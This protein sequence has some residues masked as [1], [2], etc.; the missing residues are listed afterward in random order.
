MFEKEV[1]KRESLS[2]SRCCGT[3]IPTMK[4]G[5]RYVKTAGRFVAQELI[6]RASDSPH[7]RN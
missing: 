6:M 7:K 4:A 3:N 5:H 2:I 1:E